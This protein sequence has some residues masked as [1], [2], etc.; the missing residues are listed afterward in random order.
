M[1]ELVDNL[2]RGS[3]SNVMYMILLFTLTRSRF[4]RK[5]TIVFV[6]SVFLLNMATTLWFYLYRDLTSLSRFTV[7]MFLVIALVVKPMTRLNFLQWSFTFLTTI[8]SR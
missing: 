1:K 7:L 5:A 4:G 6:S 8:I 3:V 2:L